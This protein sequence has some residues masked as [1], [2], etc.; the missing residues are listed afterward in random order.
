MPDEVNVLNAKQQDKT[1]LRMVFGFMNVFSHIHVFPIV[2]MVS[3]P[4]SPFPYKWWNERN[5]AAQGI[6]LSNMTMA[7]LSC[8]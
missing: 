2:W 5:I 3:K 6:V 4:P 1:E 8:I 7:S